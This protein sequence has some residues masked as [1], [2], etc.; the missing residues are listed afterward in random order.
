MARPSWRSSPQAATAALLLLSKDFALPVPADPRRSGLE[1][2][3]YCLTT[4][5]QL[6][7]IIRGIPAIAPAAT[8]TESPN[9]RPGPHSASNVP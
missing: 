6:V 1:A 9:S 2:P 3:L 7:M 8:V 5:P 4:S